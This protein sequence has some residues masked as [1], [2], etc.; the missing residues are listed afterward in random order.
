MKNTKLSLLASAAI[1]A[2]LAFSGT[3][4]GQV[5]DE[6]IVT[7]TKR[8]QTLQEVPVAVTVTGADVLQKAQILD[9]TDLQS[10]VPSLRVS[11]LET[12]VNTSFVI[13]GFGN[14]SNNPGIEPSVGVFIDGVYRSRAAAQIGDLP[15]L[16][17]VEVLRGPQS[18][19]FGKNAS[20]GVIGVTTS[21]PSF[22]PVGHIEVGIGN[23]DQRVLR[24]YFSTGISDTLA[25]SIG[26]SVNRRDGYTDSALPGLEDISNR[27]RWNLRAQ[28]LLQPRDDISIRLIADYGELDELCC[29]VTTVVAGPTEAAINALG[30][31]IADVNDRFSFRTFLNSPPVNQVEDGGLSLHVD[32]DFDNFA[33]TSITSYRENHTF[34]N[35]DSDFTSA[36]LLDAITLDRDIGTFTQE[37]RLTST[38]DNV[39]DWMVGGYYFAENITQENGLDLG[40][41]FGP[42]A[43]ILAGGALA[44]FEPLFGF[45]PGSFFNGDGGP[46]EVITYGQDNTAYSL[47]GTV[48]FNVTDRL[49][50]S[51]GLNYTNDRKTTSAF[52]V[53]NEPFSNIDL[54]NDP[55]V[56]G[57]PLPA[58][59]FGQAFTDSTGLAPTPANIAFIEGVA[60]GTSAAINAGVS[61]AITGLQGL[62]FLPQFLN[63]PNSVES[64]E[65]RDD[66]LTYTARAAF[67]VNDNINTYISYGTGFK[68]SSW[69][70]TRD[71]RPFAA[72]AAALTAAGLTVTNQTFG[73]RFAGPEDVR[74]I[75][76]GL[77][78]RFNKGALNIAVFDQRVDN[79]QSSTFLGTGFV[80][81]NAGLQRTRGVEVEGRYSPFEQLTLTA[82]ATFLDPIFLEFVNA[83]GPGGTT[84]DRSG[85]TVASVPKT[86]ASASATYDHDFDNGVTGFLRGDY[87][88]ESNVEISSLL[89]GI[90]RKVSTFNASA[91]ITLDNGL[92]IQVW[93]RNLFN[94]QYLTTLFPGVVQAGTI[95]G[96]PSQPRT[97]G[98]LLRKTFN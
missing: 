53:V 64:N 87:Q 75:E 72:D 35:T 82:A 90:D 18:T 71:T 77:K 34:L 46:A 25:F 78:A 62:Q 42:F 12:A 44:S 17:H 79:F 33:F 5:T 76:V 94:D 50:V 58:V 26:G 19:L 89:P 36:E 59:L 30:G 27:N 81:A 23:F 93:A 43:N 10:V 73:T 92:A 38:G 57:V 15:N 86:A 51:G 37:V 68:A 85:D 22:D 47:F 83:P 97:F 61:T 28:A 70:L 11:Q 20:A 54:V 69:N 48:D 16:Q 88:Y 91:G 40:A 24:G 14:G 31:Q 49:T 8:P 63:F 56:F 84:V 4:Y 39:V 55:T 32:V 1:T 41:D 74:L 67:A 2:G 52:A 98:V 21:K 66:A 9:I 95:N 7:A 80:L 13:R 96:Y 6:V 3:A 60:P 65:T 45:A 29:T